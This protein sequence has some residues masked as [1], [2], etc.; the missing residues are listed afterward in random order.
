MASTRATADMATPSGDGHRPNPPSTL[1]ANTIA[2]AIART[3]PRRPVTKARLSAGDHCTWGAERDRQRDI[4]R[5]SEDERLG[6][7]VERALDQCRLRRTGQRRGMRRWVEMRR[8][9]RP[10]D[11]ETRDRR[12]APGR[13][14]IVRERPGRPRSGEIRGHLGVVK[15][16]RHLS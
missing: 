2:E 15:R 1:I 9:D 10:S 5:G 8:R 16:R 14:C 11:A 4:V 12:I 13:V 7:N 3:A 6:R